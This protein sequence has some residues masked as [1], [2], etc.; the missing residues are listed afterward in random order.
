MQLHPL[1]LEIVV[2]AEILEEKSVILLRCY[3]LHMRQFKWCEKITELC[4]FVSCFSNLQLKFE[5][6]HVFSGSFILL[7]FR[8]FST[9][10]K[11]LTHTVQYTHKYS[12]R[13]MFICFYHIR[14]FWALEVLWRNNTDKI[15]MLMNIFPWGQKIQSISNLTTKCNIT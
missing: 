12:F 13:K 10:L 11:F 7:R 6:F 4:N 14:Y 5:K 9:L 3:Y 8:D 15:P 1:I 2:G